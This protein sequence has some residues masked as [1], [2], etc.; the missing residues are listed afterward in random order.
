MLYN[1]VHQCA[2]HMACGLYNPYMHVSAGQVRDSADD[3]EAV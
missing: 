1:R 3:I 2:Y